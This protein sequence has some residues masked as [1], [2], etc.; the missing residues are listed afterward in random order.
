M[1]NNV[2]KQSREIKAT[3]TYCRFIP[4]RWR[5]S[6]LALPLE[7]EGLL[8]RISAF[9][10]EA[11]VPLPACRTTTARM[12]G[13]HRNKLDK[14]LGILIGHGEI[15][16]DDNGISSPRAIMEF[17]RSQR[18]RVHQN[19]PTSNPI[20][21][22]EIP[23]SNPIDTHLVEAEKDEQ[24]LR[25][26]REE[27]IREEGSGEREARARDSSL[28]ENETDIGHGVVVNCETI[29]HESF[30]ISLP[31]V[32]MG[33]L[34]SGITADQVKEFC[35]AHALQWA[36]E[37]ANGKPASRVVPDKI[38]NFLSASIMGTSNRAASAS[39]V[40]AFKGKPAGDSPRVE[41]AR[42]F[43]A[44]LGKPSEVANVPS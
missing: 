7:V 26:S 22:P 11:G 36:V 27:K 5:Q 12:M 15:I 19:E 32:R 28:A 17:K 10:M 2:A 1:T 21:T 8:I 30:A 33:T 23:H 29:R 43:L 18:A 3:D 9:N 38:A 16:S 14:L 34:A 44:L 6:T 41:K 24:F 42:A 4:S 35:T 40:R 25:A 37:I 20:D 39:N 31:S 13:I